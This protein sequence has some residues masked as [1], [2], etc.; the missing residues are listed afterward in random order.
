MK[1]KLHLWF[2]R[3]YWS[4]HEQAS[5]AKQS[6]VL[7]VFIGWEEL[8]DHWKIKPSLCNRSL[9]GCLDVV[10]P[11]GVEGDYPTLTP[12]PTCSLS[13]LWFTKAPMIR[14]AGSGARRFSNTPPMMHRLFIIPWHKHNKCLNMM[15]TWRWKICHYWGNVVNSQDSNAHKESCRRNFTSKDHIGL[16]EFHLIA[17]WGCG[18]LCSG[19]GFKFNSD[20][21][22]VNTNR[23]K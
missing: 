2:K 22:L 10:V 14:V 16:W 6:R 3:F 7:K 11:A 1:K 13:P 18:F 23:H 17:K 5:T 8:L 19:T 15:C 12:S 9:V 20:L 21:D 4:E